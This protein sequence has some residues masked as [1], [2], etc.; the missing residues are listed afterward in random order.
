VS[1]RKRRKS[2]VLPEGQLVNAKKWPAVDEGM[3]GLMI[4]NKERLVGF[5]G[6]NPER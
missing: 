1:Q 3:S 6:E 5:I 2:I 4:K